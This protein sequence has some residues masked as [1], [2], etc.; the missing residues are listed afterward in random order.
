MIE[1][2]KTPARV[3]ELFLGSMIP[4]GSVYVLDD[5]EGKLTPQLEDGKKAVLLTEGGALEL[6]TLASADGVTSTPGTYLSESDYDSLRS[7]RG[8]PRLRSYGWPDR[9]RK[10]RSRKGWVL[11]LTTLLGILLAGYGAV[12]EKWGESAT[13]ATAVAESSQVLMRWVARPADAGATGSVRV[14]RREGRAQRCLTNL[15]GGE[16]GLERVAG[17]ECETTDPPF[18]LDKD[19][20]TLLAAF[21]GLVTALL[22]AIGIADKFRFGQRPS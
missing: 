19:N 8:N 3:P 17:V 16:G 13:S 14:S 18:L 1:L 11:L 6:K 22:G 7:K 20:K 15:R 5:P 4:D 21:I 2:S 9:W 10:V 12:L